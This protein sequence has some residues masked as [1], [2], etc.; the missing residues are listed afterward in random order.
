MNKMLLVA[1]ALAFSVMATA[2][3]YMDKIA[4]E[5]CECLEAIPDTTQKQELYMQLGVCMLVA[6]EPYQKQ[7][8][9]DHGI[10]L[11]NGEKAGEALGRLV[12]MRMAVHCPKAIL[13]LAEIEEEGLEEVE[14]TDGY[15][16]GKIGHIDDDFFVSFSI[17]TENNVFLKLYWLSP[18]ASDINLETR[19]K[20]LEGE[21]VF[22]TYSSKEFFDPR[23]GEYR[24]FNVIKTLQVAE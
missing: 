9:K 19:Y 5:S 20:K 1:A 22:V 23:I 2:Q 13:K 18:I 11:E 7:I 15:V 21:K 3:D 17:T 4:M 12:G 10:K 16:S 6:A 14:N 8:K 24:T